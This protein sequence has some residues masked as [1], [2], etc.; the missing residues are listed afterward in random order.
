M[1]ILFLFVIIMAVKNMK[2]K[3]LYK[4]IINQIDEIILKKKDI[5]IAIDGKCGSGKSTFSSF[6]QQYYQASLFKMDD[7]FLQLYQ[8]TPERLKL[9]GGN[10]DYERFKRTVIDPLLNKQ[11]VDYQRFD[12]SKMLL[13]D[14]IEVIPYHHINI[15]EGTYSLHPYFEHYYDISIVFNISDLLQE[16]RILKREGQRKLEMFK[17]KWIPLENQYFET[18]S[19]F[20]NADFVLQNE[21]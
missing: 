19:I 10:V 5:I 9:P 11:D 2:D 18:F 21:K 4:E 17:N 8:R 14:H 16:K 1:L 13:E 20:Q 7:F 15:I 3:F 12:C 6:L